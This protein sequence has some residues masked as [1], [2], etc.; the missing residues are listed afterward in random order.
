MRRSVRNARC[1]LVV[2]QPSVRA[3]DV[4]SSGSA[5]C[6]RTRIAA[7]LV[8]P[9]WIARL[10]RDVDGVTEVRKSKLF[11]KPPDIKVKFKYLHQDFI[12]F[13]PWGDNNRYW[14]VPEDPAEGTPD[15][16]KL[17]SAFRRSRSPLFEAPFA[18]VRLLKRLMGRG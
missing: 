17:E 3:S 1:K 12:V 11:S 18:S 14:I 13:E 8:P 4:T 2:P 10:L 6:A 5:S 9:I 16:S 7:R 15:I